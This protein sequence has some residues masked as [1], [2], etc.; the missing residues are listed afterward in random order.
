VLVKN[1]DFGNGKCNSM[2]ALTEAVLPATF[3]VKK[4]RDSQVVS[5]KLLALDSFLW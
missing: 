2:Q 5:Q 3:F 1:L 4:K